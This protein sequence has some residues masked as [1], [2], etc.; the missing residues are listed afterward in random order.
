[1]QAIAKPSNTGKQRVQAQG[2]HSEGQFKKVFDHRKLRVR[3]LW[4]RNGTY[5]AQLTVTD[6]QTG[7]KTVRRMRIEDKDGNPVATLADAIKGRDKL[8]VK[9]DDET[10]KIT[11]KRTPTLAEYG[12]AYLELAKG[13]K[14][15][16]TMRREGVSLK[17]L[18]KRLGHLRL[19]EITPLA[20][21]H[22]IARRQS[23]VSKRSVNLELATLRVV[24]KSA[25]E[26]GYLHSLPEIKRLEED[27]PQRRLLTHAEIEAV[28][29]KALEVA[30][31]TGQMVAD[32]IRLMAYSGGR[33]GETLRLRWDDVD[34]DREQLTFG[35]DGL[36][37]GR[38]VRAVDFNP[39][40]AAHLE[41]MRGRRAPDSN[42]LFPSRRRGEDKDLASMTFNKT[43]RDAR[44]KAGVPDFTCHMC[45]HFFAS[46]C[47]MSKV[48]IHTVA[49]WLG[50]K[51]NGV[52]LAK[53]YSHLLG[54]HKA[55]QAKAVNFGTPQIVETHQAQ[56][57][58]A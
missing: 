21:K 24:L 26:D 56:G 42:F 34:F 40:L 17:A 6:P 28:A 14:R 57:A 9:R 3:A 38:E 10:L 23:E 43:L 36:S 33:W 19:R 55:Q 22:Y 20:V 11:P 13:T 45:R 27:K 18:N 32:F 2:Q 50:H 7:A 54:E 30:P 35:A 49:D 16:H 52:L 31:I 46:M 58:K 5:Y 37:K 53:T 47:L 12:K 48:D 25:I 39:K 4:Q 51:D 44:T 15:P 41:A 1:M 29:S 8:K